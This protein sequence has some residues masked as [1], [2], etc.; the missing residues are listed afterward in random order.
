MRLILLLCAVFVVFHSS[1]H[2]IETVA[3]QAFIFDMETGS[4]LMN[5]NADER[6]PTSSMSKV[7]TMYMVFDALEGGVLSLSDRLQ[8]SEKAWRKGGSKMFVEVGKSVAVEDL[9]KGVIV[10]SGND[11]A[12][13]LAEGL[14][15]SEKRFAEVMSETAIRDL[16]MTNSHFANASGWPDPDHYSTAR[17]LGKLAAGIITRFPQYYDYYALREFT[18]N[19]IR[20][21]NRNPLLGMKIGADGIKT[22]H[23]DAAG[24][25]LMASGERN[26]RRVVMVLNG[27]DSEKERKAESA[28]LLDW[29]LR[30]FVNIALFAEDKIITEIPVIKG[31][32]DLL[33]V[34][35]A[36]GMK[37]TIPKDVKDDIETLVNYTGPLT[38]PVKRGDIVGEI[39]VNI[40]DQEARIIPLVAATSIDKAGFFKRLGDN[41]IEWIDRKV[42]GT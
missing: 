39:L 4:V 6:M 13:V 25:G 23:T 35:A 32:V 33:P 11:A 24:Y 14:Q 27:M 28:R 19:D 20:Q 21:P 18:Y 8:V 37:L 31:K 5:K 30:G 40:P 7:M 17:D 22:G 3:K 9:I 2:A 34:R 29:A 36:N 15:G 41:L 12:I 10:Q 38:A 42:G 16:G 26:D 1:A